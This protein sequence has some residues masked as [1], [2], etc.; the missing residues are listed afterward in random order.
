MPD[1]FKV[2]RVDNFA[3]ETEAERLIVGCLLEDQ[4]NQVCELLRSFRDGPEDPNWYTV[5]PQDKKL[6][7]GM[8]DL[9]GDPPIFDVDDVMQDIVELPQVD[10]DA[11][12]TVGVNIIDLRKV[13]DK[14]ANP[15]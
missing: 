12:E 9:V 10:T 1:R 15:S 2:I 14:Y 11:D 3:R 6:W 7:R 4:A 5:V 8:A 13:L